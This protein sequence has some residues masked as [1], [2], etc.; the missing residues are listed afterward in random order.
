MC[1]SEISY[2]AAVST[3]TWTVLWS[4]HP[5]CICYPPIKHP[6]IISGN[7]LAVEVLQVQVTLLPGNDSKV[8]RVVMLAIL[9]QYILIIVVFC[10]QL[11]LT[12][13]VANLKYDSTCRVCCYLQFPTVLG[14]SWNKYSRGKWELVYWP[15][16]EGNHGAH[17]HSKGSRSLTVQRWVQFKISQCFLTLLDNLGTI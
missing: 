17:Q 16:L 13:T 12:V 6:G 15:V 5:H 4:R 8:Q 7:K 2:H 1:C 3:G 9:L 11:L 10:Y 14:G